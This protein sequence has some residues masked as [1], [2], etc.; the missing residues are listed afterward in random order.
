MQSAGAVKGQWKGWYSVYCSAFTPPVTTVSV[1]LMRTVVCAGRCTL[2]L[3]SN[4]SSGKE[5]RMGDASVRR[6]AGAL[7]KLRGTPKASSPPSLSPSENS[8]VASR[9][10][11]SLSSAALT[12]DATASAPLMPYLSNEITRVQLMQRCT[13]DHQSLACE[14]RAAR[15]QTAPRRPPFCA[16]AAALQ[17]RHAS[18]AR[19]AGKTLISSG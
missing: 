11:R 12:G 15:T 4:D 7:C 6:M 9:S 2:G 10:E 16:A 14:E 19:T 18:C 5:N 8:A 17:R 13:Q 1:L 3:F